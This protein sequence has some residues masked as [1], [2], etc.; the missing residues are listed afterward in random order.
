MRDVVADP[1]QGACDSLRTA[2][3]VCLNDQ[4]QLLR[5]VFLLAALFHDLLPGLGGGSVLLLLVPIQAPL[6]I[7]DLEIAQRR[8]QV[9][10]TLS[11]R[12]CLLDVGLT[13]LQDLVACVRE[14]FP[15]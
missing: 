13:S 5:A 15:P 3:H 4:S 12:Q 1:L 6:L 10:L 7:Q 11:I 8:L 9:R 14:L 2:A